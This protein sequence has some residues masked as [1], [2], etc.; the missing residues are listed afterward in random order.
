MYITEHTGPAPISMRWTVLCLDLHGTLL[1]YLNRN[2][3]YI[4]SIRL[5]AN[6]LVKNIYTSSS[7]YDPGT[8]T[9]VPCGLHLNVNGI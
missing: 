1:T 5:C 4:K 9:A 7:E 6:M 3:T 8:N 2:Y